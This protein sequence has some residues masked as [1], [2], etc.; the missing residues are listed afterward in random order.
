MAVKKARIGD[1]RHRIRFQTLTQTSD[2]QGGQV[3]AWV[4]LISGTDDEASIWAY[5]KPVSS[6]ER[7]YAQQIEYQRSHVVT[8]RYRDDIT[9]EMRFIFDG[10]EFQ[11]KG[12]IRPDERK[13]Y[14]MFDAEE[15]QG[16]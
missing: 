2:G 12:T 1:L 11:I 14:L 9:Q 4:N 7:L 5:V 8:I 10:R 3:E 15:N 16:T 6:R 13:F